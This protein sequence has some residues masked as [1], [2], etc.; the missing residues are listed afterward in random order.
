MIATCSQFE[1]TVESPATALGDCVRL[2]SATRRRPAEASR[3][4]WLYRQNPDGEAVVWMVRNAQGEAVGFTAALP[5]RM[6]VQGVARMCW[7]GA[8]FSILPEYR[9]LGLALKLRRAAKEAIDEGQV[10]FLYSHPNERMAVIHARVGHREIGTM[11]RVAKPLCV[12][13]I[14]AERTSS[15]RLGAAAG[16]VIDP[17]RSWWDSG[18]HTGLRVRI[19]DPMDVDNSFDELFRRSTE[20]D[21]RLTVGVRDRDYL[22]WRYGTNPLYRTR[23]LAADDGDRL[24]GYLAYVIEGDE[25]H[26]KDV[27]PMDNERAARALL[28]R[29]GEIGYTERRRSISMSLLESNPLLPLLRSLGYRQREERSPMFGYCPAQ[30]PWAAAVYDPRAWRVTVG[31]RDV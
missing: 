28:Q 7:V 29:L 14:I 21:G 15:A 18:R 31:D 2:L 12:R 30:Q 11:I 1:I 26:V 20:H 8:D 4:E 24:E 25:V 6:R 9:T 3:F 16:A 19:M 17:V 22:R 13:A 5:R 23:M 27:Y 10:E